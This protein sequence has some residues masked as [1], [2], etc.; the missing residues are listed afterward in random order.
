MSEM[1]Q[2]KKPCYEDAERCI[3]IRKRAKRGEQLSKQESHFCRTIFD[4]FPEWYAETEARVFNETVPFGS[5]VKIQTTT[6]NGK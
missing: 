4:A 5:Q 2:R 6:P 3:A 1:R